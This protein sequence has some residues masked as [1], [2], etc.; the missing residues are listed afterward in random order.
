MSC[1]SVFEECLTIVPSN[2]VFYEK[3]ALMRDDLGSYFKRKDVE[4]EQNDI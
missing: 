2:F 3:M 1:K 4:I